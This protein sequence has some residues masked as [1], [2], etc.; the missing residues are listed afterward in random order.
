M[1][2]K[3]SAL[4]YLITFL[5]ILFAVYCSHQTAQPAH[6]LP[7]A[8]DG[9]SAAWWLEHRMYAVLSAWAAGTAATAL[10]R[11]NPFERVA[12]AVLFFCLY[13]LVAAFV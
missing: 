11:Q 10:L 7:K 3:T 9:L 12:L 1:K 8:S 5:L 2:Y 4:L 13:G 6:L